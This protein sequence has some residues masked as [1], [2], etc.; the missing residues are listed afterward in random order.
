[1]L[2]S[3]SICRLTLPGY[4]LLARLRLPAGVDAYQHLNPD[5]I[6]VDIDA[7]EPTHWQVY[8]SWRAR[9]PL[10]PVP[11]VVEAMLIKPERTEGRHYGG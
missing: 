7:P 4:R 2:P 11:R 8:L 5:T 6:I 1:M 10:H 9:H 3:R